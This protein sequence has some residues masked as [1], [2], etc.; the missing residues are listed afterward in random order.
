MGWLPPSQRVLLVVG[1]GLVF[2]L[3]SNFLISLFP[4]R[5]QQDGSCPGLQ[6]GFPSTSFGQVVWDCQAPISNLGFSQ[7]NSLTYLGKYERYLTLGT[8][9]GN[10]Y[11]SKGAGRFPLYPLSRFHTLSYAFA[12]F[13]NRQGKV[14]VEVGT[15]RSFQH[16]SGPG[17][18][19]DEKHFWHPQN[20]EDWDWGAGHFTAL[21]CNSLRPLL[22]KKGGKMYTVDLAG[23]HIERCKTMTTEC[24]AFLKYQVASSL[25]FFKSYDVGKNGQI[26]LLYLDTGDMTPVEVTATLHLEEVRLVVER[27]L[28][29]PSG[30]IL[31]DDVRNLTP[32]QFGEAPGDTYGK[33][34]YSID[35]LL[36]HGFSMVKSEYQVILRNS[37]DP[38]ITAFHASRAQTSKSTGLKIFHISFHL[39]CINEIEYIARRIGNGVT[40]D[41]L[42]WEGLPGD[43]SEKYNIN[44]NR[45]ILYWNHL[46]TRALQ[47]DIVITSDTVALSRIFIQ[48]KFPGKL[49]VWVCNRFDYSHFSPNV[50]GPSKKD[51]EAF[52]GDHPDVFPDREF[53]NLIRAAV[54]IP[55]Y[56][57]V[58]YTSFDLFYAK[59]YRDVDIGDEIIKPT[60]FLMANNNKTMVRVDGRGRIPANIKK[61]STLFVPPYIND[62]GSVEKCTSVGLQCYRGRYAGAMDLVG[63]KAVLHFPY[64][65]SNFALFEIASIGLLYF[66]PSKDFLMKLVKE[67]KS[68]FFFVDTFAAQNADLSEWYDKKNAPMFVYF[69]SWS[70]LANLVKTTDYEA[71]RTTLKKFMTEHDDEMINRWK[72]AFIKM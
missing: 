51:I 33:A 31:I 61:E 54:T 27:Q 42:F 49:L 11:S 63:F 40:V 22:Q 16:G 12:D 53:Y 66:I 72:T 2:L 52:A 62:E 21:A 65:W 64:A 48:N 7:W 38:A 56:T 36:L 34:K 8:F 10:D 67:Q 23:S 37:A 15:S 24:S 28:V 18:N 35:Y 68:Y 60:G 1:A 13:E 3:G 19:R 71:R 20:P 47:A 55:H 17:C 50:K 25:D 9:Q 46:K 57:F 41:S 29:V 70:D 59:K 39:G 14:I 30:L 32:K 26:D 43:G 44:H 58:G 4:P 45:A 5:V 6:A 69:D